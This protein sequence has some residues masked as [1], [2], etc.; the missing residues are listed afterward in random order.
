MLDLIKAGTFTASPA[1]HDW[2]SQPIHGEREQ[3]RIPG[4]QFGAH[5]KQIVIRRQGERHRK[6]CE[7]ALCLPVFEGTKKK[8]KEKDKLKK[9]QN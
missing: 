3:N 2:P 7:D 9:R 6:I 4:S 5:R 8:E 1:V